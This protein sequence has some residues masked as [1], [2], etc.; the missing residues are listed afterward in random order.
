MKDIA[1]IK[2]FLDEKHIAYREDASGAECTTF[3][4]GGRFALLAEPDSAIKAA[5]LFAFAR[6][7]GYPH[8]LIGNGS[9]LLVPDDGLDM[10]MIRFAGGLASF[11]REGN[12][13]VC[14]AGASLAAAARSSVMD[15]FSGLEWAA[16]IPG[17]VGG[18]VAMNAGAYGGE[19]RQVIKTVTVFR[20]QGLETVEVGPD[21]MGYRRSAF[22]F[23]GAVV[24]EA[25]FALREDDGTA[26]ARMDELNAKR[27]E[28]QPLNY[29]SAGSTFKR[30]EGHFA[31][32]L[33]EGAGLKGYS[34]GGACVS[35][36]HAG[37]VINKGGA[38][39]SDVLELIRNVQSIVLEKYGVMLEPEVR[40]LKPS[41][42]Q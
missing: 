38:T 27:R 29:P 10:L 1:L 16:G 36:K 37:F 41:E 40:I 39:A 8:Y 22:S 14:G 34:V 31:G 13:L 21:D 7:N 32:A 20:E 28:K 6:E 18:G 35:E 9:N 19:I 23:P 42:A 15:G 4:V 12:I 30:P 24:L 26:R 33:I 3:R 17:T 11:R 2:A 5:E 25:E